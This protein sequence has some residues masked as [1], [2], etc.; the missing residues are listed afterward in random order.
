MP[1][2]P[3]GALS[4]E[5]SR[6]KVPSP[7]DPSGC[8]RYRIQT[9]LPDS[10]MYKN[11]SSGEK[12]NPFGRPRSLITSCSFVLSGAVQDEHALRGRHPEREPGGDRDGPVGQA[13]EHHGQAGQRDV[14]QDAA[15][16]DTVPW[17]TAP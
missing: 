14:T 9:L 15:G 11:F 7:R 10:A 8:T 12:A 3:P 6:N 16:Q 17:N 1:S 13:G 2:G 4:D 5:G